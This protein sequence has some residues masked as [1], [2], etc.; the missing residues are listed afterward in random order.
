MPS[1]FVNHIRIHYE[2]IGS[3]TPMI[4]AHGLFG[5]WR[6]W[7]K[8]ISFF[9]DR[10]CVITYDARGHGESEVP[11]SKETY[12]QEIMVE[13][14]KGMI[15]ALEIDRAFIGGHS[16]GA[17]VALNFAIRYPEHCLACIPLGAGAG[18]GQPQWQEEIMRSMADAIEKGGMVK[19]VEL[20]KYL[21]GWEQLAITPSLW[22]NVKQ[23]IIT[24]SP[25]GIVNTIRGVQMKRST[26]QQLEP[27]LRQ[28]RVKTLIIVGELDTPCLEPSKL[29]AKL[30]PEAVLEII[31]KCDHFTH[32]EAPEKFMGVIEDFLTQ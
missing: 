20:A 21:P 31:E 27:Q 19:A 5:N 14:L 2:Q 23:N 13:D 1:V 24:S 10:Y 8:T 6:T 16:M 3:G 28:L 29:I 11:E 25:I 22:E 15:D 4:W 9:K 30:I 7:G 26:I 18:S 12:S 32:M 17:N